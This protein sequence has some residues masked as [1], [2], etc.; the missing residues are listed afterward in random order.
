MNPE[1]KLTQAQVELICTTHGIPYS[2]HERI[3]TGFSHE[4]HRLND[5]LVLKVF[6][7][8]IPKVF[9]AELAMLGSDLAF[10]KP[11]LIASDDG[12][13]VGRSYIIMSYIPGSPLG[14]VWH[15]ATDLQREHLIEAV[16]NALRT[17]NML[18]PDRLGGDSF[19]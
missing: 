17:I 11:K 12:T 13:L 15:N 4:V 1:T 2:S 9:N 16:S 8:T 19:T 6:N 18:D 10:P 3:T 5:D 14:T 7:A